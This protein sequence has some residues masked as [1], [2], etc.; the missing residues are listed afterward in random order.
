MVD[1][2]KSISNATLKRLPMYLRF[3]HEMRKEGVE[4]ISSVTIAK[5]FKFNSVQVKKDISLVSSVDGKPKVGFELK[6]LIRDL[7]NFL[8]CNSSQ[9]ACLIGVGKLGGAL[10]SYK[11]FENYGLEVVAA[12]DIN[13]A[14]AGK[15]VGRT[16]IYPIS[17][18]SSYVQNNGV[19]MA[20]IAVQTSVAQAVCDELVKAGI[21]AIMNFAP[22][23]LTVPDN[24][25][26]QNVDI[27]ASLAILSTKLKVIL[28]KRDD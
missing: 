22:V 3:L 28:D 18:L 10:L 15:R 16:E 2:N 20:I 19:Y 24:V 27:A 25:I 5:H 9:K 11:G 14:L 12:F 17:Q 13:P 26:V 7:E 1:K 4:S 6:T 23:T 21:L 8:G